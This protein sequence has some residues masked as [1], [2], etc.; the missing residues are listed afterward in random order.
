MVS[1]VATLKEGCKAAMLRVGG[2]VRGRGWKDRGRGWRRGGGEVSSFSKR[3]SV[4]LDGRKGV[5]A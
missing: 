3:R 5:R 2:H 4:M 1:S